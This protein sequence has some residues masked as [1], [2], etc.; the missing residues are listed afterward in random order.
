MQGISPLHI[1][2]DQHQIKLFFAKQSSWA[3]SW[4]CRQQN[5]M[6][7]FRAAD[8]IRLGGQGIAIFHQQQSAL[9]YHYCP[10]ITDQLG[11]NGP[12]VPYL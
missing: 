2:A 5:I 9:W 8:L 11:T 4:D 12:M 3:S 1:K 6:I 7:F 10:K